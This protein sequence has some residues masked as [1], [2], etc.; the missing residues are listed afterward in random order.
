MYWEYQT[1]SLPNLTLAIT[2]AGGH[3]LTQGAI[4]VKFFVLVE[5]VLWCKTFLLCFSA[6]KN[7]LY[8]PTIQQEWT[9]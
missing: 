9:I 6:S 7:G 3:A 8:D 5:N 4:N 1:P 2:N